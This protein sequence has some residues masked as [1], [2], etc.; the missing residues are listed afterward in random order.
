[1]TNLTTAVPDVTITENGLLVPDVA[2]ILAGRLTD[3][4]TSLGGGSE[5]LSSPQ[6]QLAQSD[7]EIVAQVYDKL[8]CLF[9]QMNPDFATGR[10]QDGIGRIY[11]QDR[12]SAQ[13][14][15]VTAT[16][17]GAVGTL[18]PAG[19]S[20]QDNA[21]YIY[22]SINDATIPASGSVEV[23]F[24][25]VTPGPIP[26]G[27][28]ELNQI[29]RA[30]SGWDTVYN[31]AAGVVGVDVESRIA[32]EARRKD[33]VARGGANTDAATRAAVLDVS[34]VADAYV[35]S[36]RLSTPVNKGST[37]F[38]VAGNSIYIGVYGG[39]DADVASAIFSKYN[40]GCNMNGNTHV[41]V[42]DKVNY[43]APYPE[44]DIQWEKVAPVRSYFRV[45]ITN[46]PDLPSDIT[47][48][49]QNMVVKVF[50]GGYEGIEKSRIGA[51]IGTGK[52]YAP[53]ISISPNSVNIISITVSLNGSTYSAAETPGID[54]IPTIQAS[55]VQVTLV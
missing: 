42:Y 48:Q 34:G 28:G 44:Y 25:N 31:Q 24:Q 20:A 5:S 38:P 43:Q 45:S 15:I 37:N 8:L 18:I 47:I 30:V 39:L 32:F 36:N 46:N 2:D 41:T 50:N 3:M 1:M 14:T 27:V 53:I 55:D 12:I 7:T 17:V 9:N 49:V 22:R 13:G 54:Q 33:S 52:Y 35:W 16:C 21:G 40:L 11:F 23:Q 4:S 51:T 19:S 6:G 10:F 29:Y 26:C